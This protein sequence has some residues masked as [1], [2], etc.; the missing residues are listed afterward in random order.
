MAWKQEKISRVEVKNFH[1]QDKS[2]FAII[3]KFLKKIFKNKKFLSK[4]IIPSLK[5]YQKLKLK[6]NN[7][8]LISNTNN[9]NMSFVYTLSKLLGIKDKSFI[10]SANSFKGLNHRFEFF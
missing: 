2:N 6:I 3:N 7:K 9:E 4:P 5:E 8:Y 10:S 1:N